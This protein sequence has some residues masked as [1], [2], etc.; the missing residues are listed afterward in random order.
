ML[1]AIISRKSSSF[2][3][4][5][6]IHSPWEGCVKP[7]EQRLYDYG[8]SLASLIEWSDDIVKFDATKRDTIDQIIALLDQCDTIQTDLEL[9][10]ST[11][12]LKAF[13][14]SRSGEW[15]RSPFEESPS[16]IL[17]VSD[18]DCLSL[19]LNFWSFELILGWI[20]NALKERLVSALELGQVR[21][22]TQIATATRL[23]AAFAVFVDAT[24]LTDLALAILHYL[25]LC[26]TKKCSE[27]AA[28]RTLLPIT[29]VVWQLRHDEKNF[30]KALSL[31]K[32]VDRTRKIRFATEH[33][34]MSLIPKIARHDEGL[35]RS[36]TEELDQIGWLFDA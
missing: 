26:M 2:G 13:L 9:L 28:N 4:K 33:S 14:L 12:S 34:V 1:K 20:A 16:T 29:C 23:C 31:M 27:F 21:S 32:R 10:Y 22:R 7:I 24:T 19:V 15:T 11:S 36:M 30:P 8:F 3:G 17:S 5:D 25:P 35:V 6:W 18:L